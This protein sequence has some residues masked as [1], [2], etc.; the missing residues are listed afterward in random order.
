[1]LDQ[2]QNINELI[3]RTKRAKKSSSVICVKKWP[4]NALQF[5]IVCA[6]IMHLNKQDII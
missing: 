2:K 5:E 6:V 3:R 4:S 1:M